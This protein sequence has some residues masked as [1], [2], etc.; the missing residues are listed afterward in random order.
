MSRY[1]PEPVVEESVR[2]HWSAPGV[3]MERDARVVVQ[4]GEVVG[5]AAIE[6]E[7]TYSWLE[8]HGEGAAEL[9]DWAAR[10]A[11]GRIYSGGWERNDHV[12]A[13]L[14]DRGFSLVRHSHRMGID[15]AGARREPVWPDGIRVRGFAEGDAEAVYET[16]METFIDSWEHTRQPYEE[17][18]H[19]T[20]SRPGFR[21][22]LWRLAHAAE[23]LA[24]I[25][26][27][28]IAPSS[29]ETGSVVI[30]GV[31]RPW[32]RLGLGRALLHESFRVLG[33]AGCARV[34]LGVDASSL[35]G[36]HRL[37]ESAGMR[38]LSTFDVYERAA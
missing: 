11:P 22:E 37:Y 38:V 4:N 1:S 19:W 25:A 29:P 12:R 5:F 13:A 21:P 36:A 30:L 34:I 3:D 18:A 16:H 35:T 6:V 17:W 28:R 10:L 20:L 33:D 2:R 32:R 7:A 31:R 24:G 26:L 9:L 14:L 27:C 15:L 23:E 8:L